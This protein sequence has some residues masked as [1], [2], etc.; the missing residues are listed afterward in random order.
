MS[1]E[2][3]HPNVAWVPG[4]RAR[5]YYKLLWMLGAAILP[6]FVVCIA[7]IQ[8]KEARRL[9][10]H[11][12]NYWKDNRDMRQL[13]GMSGAFFVVMGGYAMEEKK[14]SVDC[15]VRTTTT[16]S[17][18][19]P[20]K[21]NTRIGTVQTDSD[22]PHHETNARTGPVSKYAKGGNEGSGLVGTITPSGFMALLDNGTLEKLINT[23]ELARTQFDHQNIEDKSKA[24]VV[25]KLIVLAQ[26]VWMVAQCIGRKIA[27][28][29]IILLEIHVLIQIPFA[30]VAYC[31]WWDKPFDVAVPIVLPLDKKVFSGLEPNHDFGQESQDTVSTVPRGTHIFRLPPSSGYGGYHR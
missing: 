10:Q 9:H 8:L 31:C 27:G 19:P 18:S 28:L 1:P 16:V 22:S 24:N 7:V 23:G 14:T 29:P 21:T 2:A 5:A 25:T 17:S 12:Q 30:F 3:I 11:W 20:N 15:A 4:R 26:I 13:L 6:E